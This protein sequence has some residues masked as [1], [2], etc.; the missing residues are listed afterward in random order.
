VFNKHGPDRLAEWKQFR[1][2]LETS[3]DPLNE[4]AEFWSHAP[5]VSPYLDSQNP[6]E[7]PDPWHLVLDNRLDDL[8]ITLGMLYTIKLTR[9]FIDADCEI[10][11]SMLPEERHP[12]HF[13]IVDHKHV[14]NLKYK[15]VV[16]I[17]ELPKTK[18]RL[19]WTKKDSL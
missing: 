2:H 3:N 7:W 8:A 1:E 19:I 14:L 4:V 16:E 12:K 15:E 10:H 13:L 18:T 11:T 17:E 9:R 6:S 5:F